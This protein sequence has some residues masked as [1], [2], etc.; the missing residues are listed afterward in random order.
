MS[1]I[2]GI[3]MRVRPLNTSV[4]PATLFLMVGDPSECGVARRKF[5][6]V[7]PS[8]APASRV[9]T[10]VRSPARLARLG[11]PEASCLPAAVVLSARL[12]RPK[13][14]SRVASTKDVEVASATGKV[15]LPSC[16]VSTTDGEVA[17]A[18]AT[19]MTETTRE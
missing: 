2:T 14:P 8:C 17:S 13:L 12:A 3:C 16:D 9:Q 1:L 5:C 19:G 11:F 18:A 6:L 15:K 10:A 7:P 4:L